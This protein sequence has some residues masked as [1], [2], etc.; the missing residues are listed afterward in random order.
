M[1][2]LIVTRENLPDK[3]YGLGK[4]LAPILTEL[5]RRGIEIGYLCQADTGV[6]SLAVLRTL[7]RILNGLLGR[8]FKH[9][10]FSSLLWGILERLNM[11]RLAA[12]V[13]ARDRYT[14]VHC[15]DPLIAAGYRWFARIRWF[16]HLRRGH[17]ARWGVTEHGFGCYAQAFHEDGA[18]LGTRTLRWLRNWEAKILLKAYW[19]MAPTQLGLAQLA[20][21]L[22]IYPPP[23]TWY[24]IPHACPTLK[25][26]PKFAA[27][28]Q[29]GWKADGVY[30][31]AVGRFAPLKQF[32]ELVQA[33]ALLK[34][35]HWHLVLV[36]EGDWTPLQ[37]LAAELKLA[38]RI[39]FA[40][41]DDMGLFYSA[42]DIYVSVSRTE[43]FGLA[44]LEALAL[45][46]PAICTAVGGVPEVVGSGAWL[47]SPQDPRA[48]VYALQTLLD[49]VNTRQSWADR[50]EQWVRLWPS[51][52]E[53]ATAYLAMYRGE[54]L[55]ELTH[56]L[57]LPAFNFFSTWHRQVNAWPLCPLPPALELPRSANILVIAPHPDDE[58]LGCG[59]TLALLA[60]RE[61]HV[62]VVVVTDGG[63]G[64]PAGYFAGED[65]VAR[66]YQETRCA[67]AVL[68][69]DDVEFLHQAD[70]N[71]QPTPEI[72]AKFREIM[73]T[74]RTDWLL[75]PSVLDYHRD[76]VAI[77]LS[78]LDV[79]QQ[80]GWQERVFLYET[81]GTVPA[82]GVVDI[83]AV[84]DLKKRAT[85]CYQLPLKYCDY[86]AVSMGMATYRGLYL[87][88]QQHFAEAF[89]ELDA[90]SW[91]AVLTCL[92]KLRAS[93]S[94]RNLS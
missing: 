33:C 35:P 93:F 16:T 94:H 84:L 87:T 89:M 5:Q 90:E 19:V 18:R 61:C 92:M 22:A 78:V 88:E 3:R 37:T 36:G 8:F 47:L 77:S 45:G 42:A 53:I 12:Q 51:L 79:W 7:H 55:P 74:F 1:K 39:H 32:H 71:Y 81:W 82:T 73:E 20:R 62:K 43:A 40:V 21:D 80:R 14:H 66:R 50:A 24:R 63:Q 30:L 23:A 65:I 26:Y 28:Q 48:L 83:S 67:L 10:E 9:T 72:S 69:I 56:R 6:R 38:E 46:L 15:Q 29:L 70:G 68:G 52:P 86:T 17:T 54:P 11:G 91:Y 34:H 44:N 57:E 58:T 13:M 64:D 25:R 76:H 27:R 75:L 85:Q 4:S 49:D 60:Q 41:S 31:L 59:G 2:L